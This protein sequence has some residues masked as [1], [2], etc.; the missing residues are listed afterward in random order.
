V[1]FIVR[2]NLHIGCSCSISKRV[3]VDVM[4]KLDFFASVP[5]Q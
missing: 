4:Y 2:N 1:C 3:D 5:F